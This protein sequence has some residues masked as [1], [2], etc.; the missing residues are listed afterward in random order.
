MEKIALVNEKD[1]II[2]FEEKMEVHYK[3]LLHRAFSVILYNDQGEMLLQQRS[4]DKYHSPGLWT[5]SCCSH[6]LEADASI[7]EAAKRRTIEELGVLVND[8]KCVGVLQYRCDFENEL[9]ENEID[10]LF[11]GHYD[12]DI[13]F[14]REE[15]NAVKW[16]AKKDILAW[17]EKEP[18]VF[19]YWFKLLIQNKEIF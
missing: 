3:G 16:M 1:E 8:L 10:S 11:I 2:G 12:G 17:I 5:N 18:E 6:Q 14:N 15:I 9:I 19:T 7:L 13:P 4:Y